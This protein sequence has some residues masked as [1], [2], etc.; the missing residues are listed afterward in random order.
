MGIEIETMTGNADPGIRSALSWKETQLVSDALRTDGKPVSI[1]EFLEEAHHRY[2]GRPWITGRFY[3]NHL[4]SRGVRPTD[5]VLDFGCGSGRVG[6]WLIPYL[7]RAR[8]FGIDAHLRSLLAFA[9]YEAILHDLAGKSPRLLLD[10]EFAFD[11]FQATFDVMLDFSVSWGLPPD[12]IK[13]AYSRAGKCMRSG[14][15]VFLAGAPK[16]SFP[17]LS[18]L[19]FELTHRQTVTY[20]LSLHDQSRKA[21]RSTDEWHELTRV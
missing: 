16:L 4:V 9:E 11:R 17:E 2:Y 1:D 14:A 5:N 6:I 8:Y 20:P 21:A 13:V 3:F 18:A 12:L 19:G 7:E 10:G 15:R